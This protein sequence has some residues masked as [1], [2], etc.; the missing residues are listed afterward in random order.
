MT[1][2]NETKREPRY[3]R[4]LKHYSEHSRIGISRVLITALR[5]AACDYDFHIDK[6]PRFCPNCGTEVSCIVPFGNRKAVSHD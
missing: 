2:Q 6:Q 5:C 4:M 3:A 1:P